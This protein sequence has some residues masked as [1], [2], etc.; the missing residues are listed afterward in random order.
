MGVSW[1]RGPESLDDR[2]SLGV[3]RKQQGWGGGDSVELPTSD[4]QRA[5]RP[6]KPQKHLEKT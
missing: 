5:E 2:R 3:S 4:P 1:R 6:L